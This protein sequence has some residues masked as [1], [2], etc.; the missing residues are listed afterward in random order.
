LK[1]TPP[2]PVTI[3]YGYI[4]KTTKRGELWFADVCIVIGDQYQ[5]KSLLMVGAAEKIA[6]A[7]MD[8]EKVPVHE[9]GSKQWFQLEIELRPKYDGVLKRMSRVQDYEY[10]KW[11]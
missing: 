8:L 4:N 11:R 6:V 10:E 9:W 1:K 5:N 7:C 2:Y 3:A